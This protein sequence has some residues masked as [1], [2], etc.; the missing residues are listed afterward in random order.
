VPHVQKF[1]IHFTLINSKTKKK[2]KTCNMWTNRPNP[3][4]NRSGGTW[5]L[6]DMFPTF[7]D[8]ALVWNKS[9]VPECRYLKLNG[10][11]DD[12]QTDYACSW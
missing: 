11:K 12:N 10:L 6:P 1:V 4:T 7:L 8:F 5:N 2:K 3:S 9:L